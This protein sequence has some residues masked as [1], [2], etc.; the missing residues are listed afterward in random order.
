MIEIIV[1]TLT[2]LLCFFLLYLFS[3]ADFVLLRQNISLSQIFD[4]AG[5]S[6]ISAF[7]FSR[8]LYVINNFKVDLLSFLRFFHILK[9]PG[10]SFFGFIA[11]GSLCLYLIFI[12][13]KGIGRITDIFTISFFPLFAVSILFEKIKGQLSFL[14]YVFFLFCILIFIFFI[15]SH[16]KYIL[17]DGSISL[18]FVLL[19]CIETVVY[20]YLTAAA[21]GIIFS[22][23]ILAII[24]ILAIPPTILE[25]YINQ[26][27]KKSA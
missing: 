23:S 4:T 13:K 7:L 1:F 5:I 24:G 19:V 3:K 16:K 20:Q 9:Y 25:L 21:S 6:L 12:K 27:R 11:G 22:F 10:L 14:P 2:F 18:L 26:K 15:R 17:K 8:V